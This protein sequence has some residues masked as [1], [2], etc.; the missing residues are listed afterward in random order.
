MINYNPKSWLHLIFALHKSDTLKILWKE[1]IYIG[2]FTLGIAYIELNYYPNAALEKLFQVF[3]LV[4]FVISLLLVFRTNTAYDRWWEGR[5]KWGELVNDTRNFGA[6]LSVLIVGEQ[7]REFFKRMI[8]NFVFATKEHLREGVKFEELEMTA[9]ENKVLTSKTHVPLAIVKLIYNQ[10]VQLKKSK[11]ITEEDFIILDKNCNALMNSLGAC[12]R[13]K[14]TPIPFSY[15]LFIKKFIFIY[16]TTLPLA[17]VTTFGYFSALIATFVFYILVSM[18]VLAEE[19]E[20]PFGIDE[21]D[22]PT[23]ILCEKIKLNIHEVFSEN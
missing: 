20:D 19:I 13:I 22:L 18:E 15:S 7:E 6:K 23:D 11:Q 4:G 14:N 5:K 17:F 9:S 12:E 8:P 16:V 10:L 21:N 3:S 1:I 2:V